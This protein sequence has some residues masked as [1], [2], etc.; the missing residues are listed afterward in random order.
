MAR[1]GRGVP[2]MAV[3]SP[4]WRGLLLNIRATP[5]TFE[6]SKIPHE[7]SY[8]AVAMKV[9]FNSNDH[10][11]SLSIAKRQNSAPA[12]GSERRSSGVRG[13]LIR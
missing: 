9:I 6:I 7:K 4:S 10:V 13:A 2:G 11:A 3:A 12:P 5:R 1:R 8:E